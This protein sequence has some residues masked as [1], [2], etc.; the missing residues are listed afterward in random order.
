[1]GV[2]GMKINMNRNHIENSNLQLT[3][4]C[5][6]SSFNSNRFWACST[7]VGYLRFNTVVNSEFNRNIFDNSANAL[8]LVSTVT[9]CTGFNNVYSPLIANTTDFNFLTGFVGWI[10]Q[11][12]LTT[13]VVDEGA[14]SVFNCVDRSEMRLADYPSLVNDNRVWQKFCRMQSTGV[15][16][17]DTTTRTAGGYA[18]RIEPVSATSM[19]MF[20]LT[21]QE[22][23]VPTG[24][25]QNKTMT[26]SIWCNIANSAYATG[27]H[28]KPTLNV[29]YDNTTIIST[30]ALAQ[31]G[32]WQ[33]LAL[34]FTPLTQFGRIEWWVTGAT[35]A[36]GT[37]LYGFQLK[38][39]TSSLSQNTTKNFE[40][41]TIYWEQVLT[42]ILFKYDQDKR[43]QLKILGQNDQLQ[44]VAI[45]Q[46]DVQY[47]LGQVNGM[48]LSGGSAATGTAFGDRNGF[49]LIFTG[50]EA[51]PARVIE[52]TLSSVFAGASIVD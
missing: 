26:V 7:A 51:E 32:T 16:L 49:E 8:S 47:L 39:N 31:Y 14:N 44:I 29:K 52:G 18:M 6:V 22:R 45:D 9:G 27:V 38:R 19:A 28:T 12:P 46:N 34:T 21:T 41:G 37:T 17:A 15:G 1:M 10:E 11:T 30:V 35:S 5:A 43:N 3:F 24:N 50:Q 36:S 4:S 20:P 40:N 25:I 23:S 42:A 33:L 2:S 48:Y 13:V